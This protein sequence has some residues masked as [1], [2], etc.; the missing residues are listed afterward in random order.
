[1][2]Q[3]ITS[4]ETDDKKTIYKK[5]EAYWASVSCDINGMLGGFKHLHKPDI[6]DSRNFLESLKSQGLL[7]KFERAVDCGCG[8]GRVTKHL[9][10]PLFAS[11]DMVDITENF[12]QGSAKYIGEE[13]KRIGCKLICGLQNFE[14][15]RSYYDLIWIQWV[16]GHLTDDDFCKFFQRCREGLKEGGCIVLK[17]NVS[18]SV[19]LYDFDEKDN[20]W[21]RP[22]SALLRLFQGA[23]L[24]I[25]AEKKQQ[26]FP[27]GMLPVYMFALK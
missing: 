4:A 25:V 1:M 6:Y 26:N 15:P 17:E 3:R 14:P 24:T 5:A 7:A 8:I 22:K 12:I 21:T 20:S 2:S 13:G 9:L 27:R 10:L 18:S 16:T 19:D 11:V 23:G